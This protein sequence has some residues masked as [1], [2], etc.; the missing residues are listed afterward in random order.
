MKTFGKILTALSVLGGIVALVL[1]GWSIQHAMDIDSRVY[2]G[3]VVE[4]ALTETLQAGDTH[5]LTAGGE[6]A[7][8]SCSASGPTGTVDLT[9]SEENTIFEDPET[10]LVG[11]L[12]VEESGE[13]QF[14]CT[15]AAEVTLSEPV[16]DMEW[17][18]MGMKLLGGVLLGGLAFLGL[19][20]G[21]VL[22]VVGGNRTRREE[23]A[24][25]WHGGGPGGPGM[26][27]GPSYPSQPGGGYG[28]SPGP[29]HNP[30]PPPAP[31]AP[32]QSA[33]GGYGQDPYAPTDLRHDQRG[34]WN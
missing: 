27:V 20:L 8:A 34:P 23:Q 26:P 28:P 6:G 4:G 1:C 24:R 14:S 30:G 17:A 15:G 3:P 13:Y 31:P 9:P 18:T 32:E 5:V 25:Q 2:G 29:Q 33:P 12:D 10:T 16:D 21:I 11:A 19:A 7:D 22:W